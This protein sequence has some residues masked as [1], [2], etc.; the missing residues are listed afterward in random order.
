MIFRHLSIALVCSCLFVPLMAHAQEEP[1]DATAEHEGW[2]LSGGIGFTATPETFLMQFAAPYDFGNGVSL[3]PQL[4]IG[5]TS[6]RT[7]V[8]SA[9]DLRYS[10]DLFSPEGGDPSAFRPFVNGGL[11]LAYLKREFNNRSDR[12]DVAFLIELGVG[13]EYSINERVS[14]ESA[15]QFNILPG[16]LLGDHFYYSWQLVGVRYKF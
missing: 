10:F 8:E 14:L 2:S 5:V 3:G 4:Q 16:E 9:L 11:G 6:R 13:I 12:D 1:D 7:L 15:M